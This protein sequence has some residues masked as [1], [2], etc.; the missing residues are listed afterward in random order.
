M[1][2]GIGGIGETSSGHSQGE[3]HDTCCCRPPPFCAGVGRKVASCVALMSLDKLQ[4]I[5][6]DTHVWQMAQSLYG[7]P[8]EGKS[9]TERKMDQVRAVFVERFGARAG[10]AQAVLFVAHLS[11]FRDRVSHVPGMAVVRKMRQKVS[12]IVRKREADPPGP[13][14][15]STRKKAPKVEIT[16]RGRS[17]K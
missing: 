16:R 10:W 1:W 6:V 9:L 13:G 4:E 11:D 5:P 2:R 14:V 12:K 8:G 3:S 7:F 17:V 15:E